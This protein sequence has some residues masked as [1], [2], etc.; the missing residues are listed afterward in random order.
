M[1]SSKAKEIIRSFLIVGFL[2]GLTTVSHW[3]SQI[4]LDLRWHHYLLLTF[5]ILIVPVLGIALCYLG[6]ERGLRLKK[7]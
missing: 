2:G 1:Q 4:G 5:Q 7:M 6:Y 3:I